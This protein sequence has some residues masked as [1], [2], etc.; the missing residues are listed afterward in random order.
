MVHQKGQVVGHRKF[1]GLPESAPYRVKAFRQLRGSTPEKL[2]GRLCVGVFFLRFLR[3]QPG[4]DFFSCMIQLFP[5]IL[6]QLFH[7]CQQFQKSR[8]PV[9]GMLW[10]IGACIEGL[11]I[12]SHQ[13]GQRPASGAGHG[14]TDGHVD[15]VYVRPFL[16]VD[17][18]ADKGTVQ[19]LRCLFIFKGFVCHYMAPVA[20]AVS[21]A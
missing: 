11:L 18:D 21:N 7:L 17:L 19:D 5:L 16:P 12:R 9:T 10:K 2:P 14:L 20:G 15:G 8:M 4:E 1:G 13:D 3:L 6:P